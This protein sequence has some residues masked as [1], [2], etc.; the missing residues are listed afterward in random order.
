MIVELEWI[1]ET[2]ETKPPSNSK[3]RDIYIQSDGCSMLRTQMGLEERD[4][5]TERGK[6]TQPPI[7]NPDTISN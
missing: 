3:A 4:P 2:K 7:P 5:S 1:E 6:W